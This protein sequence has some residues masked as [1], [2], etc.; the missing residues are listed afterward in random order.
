ME[1]QRKK[2]SQGSVFGRVWGSKGG[3]FHGEDGTFQV[4]QGPSRTDRILVERKEVFH[5]K[6]QQVLGNIPSKLQHN[7]YLI[8]GLSSSTSNNEG[9]SRK[10]R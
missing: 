4:R 5:G 10:A 6:E 3:E 9:Q 8:S 7:F 1:V 2:R